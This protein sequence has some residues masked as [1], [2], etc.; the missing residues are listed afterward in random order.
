MLVL[1]QC[2]MS[3]LVSLIAHTDTHVC[4][5]VCDDVISATP[6]LP[7]KLSLVPQPGRIAKEKLPSCSLVL[8]PIETRISPCGAD[9]PDVF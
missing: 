3:H 5:H 2:Y 4:A 9:C 1:I 8:S 7:N 6:F